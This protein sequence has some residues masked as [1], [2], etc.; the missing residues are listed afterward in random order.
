MG[1]IRKIRNYFG[2]QSRF[3]SCSHCGDTWNWKKAEYIKYTKSGRNS[4]FPL[5]KEC[6]S[7]LTYGEVIDYCKALVR[8]WERQE[9]EYK[10]ILEHRKKRLE[11]ETKLDL[12]ANKNREK[13]DWNVIRESIR[14]NK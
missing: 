10:E 7:K 12:E 3:G 2:R 8:E 1:L 13:V 11:E 9:R 5:C 14:L 4:M 6:F